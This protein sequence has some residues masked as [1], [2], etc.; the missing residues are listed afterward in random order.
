MKKK[1]R[2]RPNKAI[3][4]DCQLVEVTDPVEQALLDRRCRA[5]ERSL[6]AGRPGPPKQKPSGGK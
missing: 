6:A 2:N 3:L 4:Q 1:P 5:A